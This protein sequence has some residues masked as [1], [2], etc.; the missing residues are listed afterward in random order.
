M[1][2]HYA[3]LRMHKIAKIFANVAI[4]TIPCFRY[5]DETVER[6]FV[7]LK[8]HLSTKRSHRELF[9]DMVFDMNIF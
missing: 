7:V 1:T 6:N 9:I 2:S 5:E 4:K 3:D 8:I